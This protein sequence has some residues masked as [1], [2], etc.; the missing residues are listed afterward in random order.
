MGK[1]PLVGTWKLISC[2]VHRSDGRV[3]YP[4]GRTPS[5]YIMYD[6]AGYMLVAITRGGRQAFAAGSIHRATASE[7]A[8]AAR[9]YLSYAGRYALDGDRVVHHVEVSLYPDW[10]GTDLIREVELS[11]R[12]L[13]LTSPPDQSGGVERKTQIVWERAKE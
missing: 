3:S 8:R 7:K 5:G 11:G 1:N 2:E 4:Y 9:T 12:R 6:E 10:V 13:I